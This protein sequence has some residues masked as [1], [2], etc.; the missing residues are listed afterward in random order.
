[1]TVSRVPN[2]EGGIQPTIV[3]AKGDLITAVANANPARLGV[4]SDGQ[5]LTADSTS[6]TGLSYQNNFAAGKNK[7][8]NGDFRFN[9]RNFTSTTT[10]QSY[11]FDRW[12]LIAS[13][14]CTY[15]AQT[16]TIGTAPVAGYEAINF[17][18]LVTTGQSGT[19]VY[20]LLGQI[21]EDV[22]TF[23]G[24]TITVSFWAK[25]ASGTPKVA[26]DIAQVFGSGGSAEVNTAAGFVTLSTSWTRYSLTATVPSVSGKTLTADNGLGI[27]LWVSAGTDFSSRAS[28]IG[29]QS[30]TFDVW[31]IQA[32][33]GSTATAFQTA[34]GTIQGELAACQRYY[35]RTGPDNIYSTYGTGLSRSTTSAYVV[36][37]T[38]VTM[39]VPPSAVD[40]SGVVSD[41]AIYDGVSVI[42]ATTIGFDRPSRDYISLAITVASG[43]TTYRPIAFINNNVSTA[44]LGFSAEL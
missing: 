40:G 7:L 29:I 24:Q 19:G 33:A 27:L 20:S 15:S 41:Y 8:I 17:A 5:L 28:S 38:A 18:R 11:G 30:N 23:A 2:V 37:K 42:A 43:L 6:A 44:Y 1:M 25:A 14:G 12:K 21:I 22:R 32:E 3:T 26:V 35:W 39:R 36:V 16:F 34:T 31:G 9:Q 10:N 4:G 13:S